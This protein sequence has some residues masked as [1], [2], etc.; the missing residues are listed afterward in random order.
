MFS[1][2]YNYFLLFIF[3]LFQ[4]CT[5]QKPLDAIAAT[6]GNSEIRLTTVD[7]MIERELFNL[8]INGVKQ[9]LSKQLFNIEALNR[10]VS[11]DSLTII[12]I[13]NKSKIPTTDDIAIFKSINSDKEWDESEIHGIL[14]G[15]YQ[16]ERKAEFIKYLFDKYQAAIKIFPPSTM[17]INTSKLFSFNITSKVCKNEVILVMDFDCTHCIEQYNTFK[18]IAEKYT[19]DVS[20]KLIYLSASYELPGRALMAAREQRI[21]NM[22]IEKMIHTP[23]E[24]HELSFYKDII[25]NSS[26]NT[27]EFFTDLEKGNSIMDLLTTRDYLF[28]QGIHSTPVYIING[29]LYDQDDMSDYLDP[30]IAKLILKK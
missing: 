9:V 6:I 24:I 23:H 15:I 1:I 27:L 14:W 5:H 16:H 29:M 28:E 2:S 25:Q 22:M 4:A 20:F 13:V 12:E 17:T 30:L 8:R 21:E 3:L 18:I 10:N 7:S 26:A 19:K 11:I